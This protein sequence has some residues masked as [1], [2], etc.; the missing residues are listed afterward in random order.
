MPGPIGSATGSRT[1]TFLR[2]GS[3]A[4][5]GVAILTLAAEIALIVF[6]SEPGRTE[7]R[8]ALVLAT[9]GSAGLATLL[10]GLGPRRGDRDAWLALGLG[11][12]IFTGGW[13]YYLYAQKSVTS[14]P[15]TADFFW[16]AFYP[17]LLGT[18]Y[19]LVRRQHRVGGLG[20]SLDAAIIAI[21]LGALAYEL[22]F[23][24]LIAITQASAVVGGQLSY[25]V[26]DLAILVLLALICVPSRAAVGRAYLML[27]L[28]MAVLLASDATIVKQLADGSYRPGTILDAGWPTAIV[29][30]GLAPRFGT[31]LKK[32]SALRGTALNLAIL[33]AFGL[34][35]GLLLQEALHDQDPVVIVLAALVPCLIVVRLIFAVRDN[36]R[37]ARDNESIIAAAG[38]GIYRAD[39][40]GRITSA[41]P[42]ALRMLG[43]TLAEVLG[44]RSHDLLHHT[45]PNGAP[46]PA[47]ECP[48]NKT[49]RDGTTHRVSDEVFWRKD[50]TSLAVDYTTAPVREGGRIVGVVVVFDDVTRQRNL[51]E[52]LREQA[53]HDSL[54]GLYNRRR[55]SEEVSEQLL[56]A[57]RYRRPGVLLMMDLDSFKF[58]N[59]SFGHP[60]GDKLLCDVA[61][62]LQASVRETDVVARIGGDEFAVLLREAD[63]AQG[64]EVAEKLIAAIRSRSEPTVG[65]SIGA[66]PFDGGGSRT[67]D[68]LLIA[69]DIALY[70]AKEA[71]GGSA[72]LYTGQ[73]GKA[74]TWVE[75]IRDALHEGRVIVDCQPIVDLRSGA[76]VREELLVRL[77]DEHGD[78]IPPASFLPAAERFGLIQEIDLLVLERAIELARSGK[79]V[80]AN[81]SART[82][83]D[84]RYFEALEQ[85]IAGGLDPGLFNFEITETAAVANM[86]EAQV[87]ARRIHEIG[88]SLAL[89]DF[90][91]GFSSFTYLKHIPAQYLKIDTEFI[92]ELSHN[93]GDQQLVGAIVSIARGLGQKTVAEGVEDEETLALVRDLGVDLVQGFELGGPSTS[94]TAP[95]AKQ[96]DHAEHRD[97][98][99]HPAG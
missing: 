50:G 98:T 71:G 37:L 16:L 46:Y 51:R 91:T 85:A 60:V 1:Q 64:I 92:R 43:Y 18:V 70:E 44:Q 8:D 7:T 11:I 81:V 9:M 48:S 13:A 36:D 49:L 14:F 12:L 33:A 34:S 67:P 15:S 89:D 82:L 39:A 31:S 63:R 77:L 93:P 30:L 47:A 59:D 88:A 83:N 61:A 90:G 2:V 66:A 21:A 25:S 78:K 87:F 68:D 74:L 73:R 72:I 97:Q 26:L 4:L 57:Q 79:A 96:G 35:F 45:R 86:A 6:G 10:A 24:G 65:A 38:E 56:Y 19:L 54:T 22:V 42:A 3:A 53:D 17:C 20:I 95:S 29:L 75:R 69:A 58:V 52:Q 84:P 5:L 62:V 55:L 32:I 76:V 99:R 28:G 27:I 94:E 40:D 41:N 80:A 23:N